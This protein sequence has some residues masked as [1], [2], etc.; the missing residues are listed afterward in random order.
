MWVVMSLAAG[1]FGSLS[2]LSDPLAGAG[3]FWPFLILLA[4]SGGGRRSWVCGYFS[5]FGYTAASMYWL[6]YIP[7]PAGAVAG[8]LALSLYCAVYPAIWTGV[9]IWAWQVVVA[10][11]S[12]G[13]E[14]RFD[15]PILARGEEWPGY[16]KRIL[17]VIF[18][19][20]LWVVIEWVRSRMI[21]GFPWNLLGVSQAT[22]PFVALLAQVSGVS[23][24]SWL[25]CFGSLLIGMA[26]M[27]V[28]RRPGNPMVG[29]R[30]LTPV[31]LIGLFCFNLSLDYAKA[32]RESGGA[33]KRVVRIAA[34]QP[35]FTQHEIWSG[36]SEVKSGMWNLLIQ[37]TREALASSETL[38]LVIW[39]EGAASGMNTRKFQEVSQLAAEKGVPF[40]IS[41]T[42]SDKRPDSDDYD[43][44]NS[45]V[46]IDKDGSFVNHDGD[47]LFVYNKQHLVMFGEYIP[48]VSTFPWL[49]KLI[50]VGDFQR[51]ESPG[52]LYLEDADV[53]ISVNIC[54]ED[55]MS[56]LIHKSINPETELLVNLTNDAW[57]GKSS[58]QWQHLRNGLFRT[59]ELG[60]PS[61]KSS[62]NGITC[63]MSPDG[64][65]HST[66]FNNAPEKS[67]YAAGF[68]LMEIPI[69]E[70]R[71]TLFREFG[72]WWSFLSMGVSF[73]LAVWFLVHNRRQMR[74]EMAQKE[75]FV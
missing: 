72:D 5:G 13:R 46:F 8:W 51:G 45:A 12:G 3:W 49:G 67:V 62:N 36:D 4:V 56:P 68:K 44:F 33:D 47:W 41:V 6:C 54:F 18:S 21:T 39:P 60:L 71:K 43:Y 65:V 55:V 30:E 53:H 48:F 27:T 66:H 75:D 32:E 14:L 38:D 23:L 28:I 9:S 58:A 74:D 52:H 69:R 40:L 31:V 22:K 73:I 64:R 25:V 1:V 57:F 16:W 10:G 50:P 35:G 34:V 11:K 29:L 26:V 70:P 7:F 59:I 2:Y 24:V 63:W 20:S 15:H 42:T 17:W 19:A 37:L 61:V